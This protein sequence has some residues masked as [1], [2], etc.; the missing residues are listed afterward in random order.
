MLKDDITDKLFRYAVDILHWYVHRNDP[1][2]EGEIK[3]PPEPPEPIAPDRGG[4]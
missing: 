1:V 4:S 2:E 3:P